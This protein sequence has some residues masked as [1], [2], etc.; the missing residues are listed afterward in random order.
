MPE[1]IGLLIKKIDL[2]VRASANRYLSNFDLTL[3]QMRVVG[4]LARQVNLTAQQK[5]ME[6]FFCVAHPTMTG[7]VQR[8]ESKG[9]VVSKVNETDKR[10]KMIAL[11][12]YGERAAS[13][14]KDHRRK[15]ETAMSAGLTEGE[16]ETLASLLHRVY[17]N[18]SEKDESIP[19]A[20][21]ECM[22]EGGIS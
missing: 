19:N 22:G 11:T 20:Q 14:A 13:C 9:L 18:L 8:L 5:T 16:K 4:F 15:I 12:E 7:I 17:E 2:S 3:T 21:K 1:D 6:K 10:M